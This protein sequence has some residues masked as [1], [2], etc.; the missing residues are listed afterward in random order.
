VS[1]AL[2][3]ALTAALGAL[4]MGCRDFERLEFNLQSSAVSGASVSYDQIHFR[5]GLALAVTAVPLDNYGDNMDNSTIIAL[6][7]NDPSVIGV[8]PGPPVEQAGDERPKP[9][10]QFVIFGAGVGKS[11]VSVRIDG[12]AQD[13]IP[14]TVD[15]P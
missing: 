10:W 13:E 7:S 9:N 3:I 8:E 2:A 12:V 5:E 11:A 1:R 14:A 4:A 6:Q 15:P